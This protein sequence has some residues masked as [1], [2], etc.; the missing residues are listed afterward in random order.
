[1][2]DSSPKTYSYTLDKNILKLKVQDFIEKNIDFEIVKLVLKG[3]PFTDID[4]RVLAE[5]IE[6][7]KKAEKKLPTWFHTKNIYYPPKVSIEQTSSEVTA[8]Y[9]SKLVSGD[10]LADLTGGFGVDSYYFSKQIKNVFHFEVNEELSKI[11]AHNFKELKTNMHCSAQNGIDAIK[12]KSFDVIYIDPSRRNEA[13]GKVFY[14]K[15]CE[16]DV[17]SH[18]DY[19]LDRSNTILIK[20]SPMLD[21][22]IGLKELKYVTEIH[23]V[24]VENDVK[25]L[26]WILNKNHSG[27]YIIKAVNLKE[28][29]TEGFSLDPETKTE[30]TFSDP[31]TYLYEPNA[32]I[33]KSGA[34]EA[35]SS[36]Y[37]IDKLEKNTHLY[38]SNTLIDFPGRR[39][40]IERT[41]PYSKK[42]IKSLI[43][44][45]ANVTTRNFP[46]SVDQIR[47]KWK[48]GEGGN[49][50]LFFTTLSNGK[51]VILECSKIKP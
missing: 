18:L 15:D 8:E 41:L 19:L 50:Y 30:A 38:T 24:A 2:L 5:Q 34:F 23:I 14:L 28:N 9:K 13:K 17:I 4:I 22:S 51:K 33:M 47:K 16:P 29:Y 49:N 40:F 7:K 6:S 48:I 11:A 43:S 10:T 26:L 36:I 25:E 31:K 45:K 42:D 27:N 37:N 39:F 1:M 20:T 46:E 44:K 32:A 3:S 21:I 12:N 35:V